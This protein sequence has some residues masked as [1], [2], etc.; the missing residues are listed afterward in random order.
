MHMADRGE[1][2]DDEQTATVLSRE[3][4][5]RPD[6]HGLLLATAA[7][8]EA[9]FGAL[10]DA[11]APQVYTLMRG[12]LPNTARVDLVM[13]EALVKVWRTAPHF[14]ASRNSAS[15]WVCTVAYHHAV[16]H[17]RALRAAASR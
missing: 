1:S 4:S 8:D 11:L 13:A 3:S 16:L 10:Y 6:L 15:A 5:A 2:A 9:A 14:D 7:G 17:A 12:V